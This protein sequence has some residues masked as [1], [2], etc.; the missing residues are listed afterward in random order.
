[1]GDGGAAD[2]VRDS[3]EA[4]ARRVLAALDGR[5]RIASL[6]RAGELHSLAAAYRVQAGAA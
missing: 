2:E 4:T 5:R 6:E 3:V 1:M